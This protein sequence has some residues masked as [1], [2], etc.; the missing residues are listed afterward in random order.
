MNNIRLSMN[1]SPFS[2]SPK[3]I[4]IA[5]EYLSYSN[6]YDVRE[7]RES[8]LEELSIY[9]GADKEKIE[10]YPGSSFFLTLM[11]VYAR[12]KNLPIVAPFPTFHA[13]YGLASS[14][15]IEMKNVEL[16]G[17]DF[18]LNAEELLRLSKGAVAYISN[19]NNP[20]SNMLITD[21]DLVASIAKQSELVVIDEAYFEFS[22]KTFSSMVDEF[23]NLIILRTL[24]KAFSI[25]GARVGYTISSRKLNEKFERLRIGY[26]VPVPSQA[27][28]L[29]A[30]KD[31]DHM[32]K[33]VSTIV[34]L[35]EAVRAELSEMGLFSPKSYTNFLFVE[36]PLKCLEAEKHFEEKGI[37]TLCLSK[38]PA[39]SPKYDRWMRITIGNE[40][41]MKMLLE[42]IKSFQR[43][44][45]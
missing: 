22:G 20:T 35:R 28:A 8:L 19:P 26:D 13:L 38:V 27:L 6:R 37:E 34:R 29:G 11:L 14:Y 24:S 17:R 30:L 23:E 40:D 44:R 25:A 36:L 18:E 43:T 1:E 7:L 15:G 10:I 2:P 42:T 21:E 9:S 39:F 12:I 41:E 32:K 4:E 16:I 45:T 33:A 3:A 5:K 31:I